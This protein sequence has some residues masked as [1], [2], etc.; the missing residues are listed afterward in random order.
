MLSGACVVLKRDDA[1][2]VHHLDE[3]HDVRR[4]LHDL[5]EVVVE[6]RQH[7]RTG[8]R[9]EAHDAAFAERPLFGVVVGARRP[10]LDVLGRVGSRRRAQPRR[11][12]LHRFRERR[13]NL[14]IRRVDD[15]RGPVLAVDLVVGVARIDPEVVVAADIA[16]RAG[17][18]VAADRRRLSVAVARSRTIFAP[19]GIGAFEFPDLGLRQRE[20][21]LRFVRTLERRHGREIPEPL[22]VRMPPRRLRR[23]LRLRAEADRQ[24]RCDRPS[25]HSGPR[26]VS[27]RHSRTPWKFT[28]HNFQL[29]NYANRKCSLLPC[30]P[31]SP[32]PPLPP[33]ATARPS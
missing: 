33:R 1:R 32:L 12:A 22:Q 17:R 29:L 2:V 8:D 30:S 5:L 19:G 15:H 27:H 4:R 26:E 11:V 31:A 28:I 13:R 18:T 10:R 25:H 14:A 21:A 9:P 6:H 20:P 7:R 24:Q 3:D 23:R 16:G